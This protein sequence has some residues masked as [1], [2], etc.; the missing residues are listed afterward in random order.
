M[1]RK[2]NGKIVQLFIAAYSNFTIMGICHLISPATL[3]LQ[4]VTE[5]AARI[6]GRRE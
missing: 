3:K 5:E 2:K 1:R 4:Y 6:L